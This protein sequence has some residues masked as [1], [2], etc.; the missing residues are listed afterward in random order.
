[1][2]GSAD[3]TQTYREMLELDPMSQVF[4]LLAEELCAEGKW[5][6]AAQVCTGGLR[7]HPAHTRA[8]VLLG[9]ALMELGEADQSETVL[10]SVEDEIR[11]NAI[12][13]KFLSEF[14][15]FSGDP[16]R[17]DET[18]RIYNAFQAPQGELQSTT[19]IP[20][21]L[22]PEI[23]PEPIPQPVA[24]PVQ[25]IAPEPAV[26][27]VPPPESLPAE[28]ALKPNPASR[29]ES[30]FT[31]VADNLES[32]SYEAKAAP[33]VFSQPDRNLLKQLLLFELRP[34]GR[35]S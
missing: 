4:A 35:S 5:E 21:P 2:A 34:N 14:A 30:L 17:A 24:A 28:A 13:F 7:Y 18:A 32:E 15:A 8:R 16:A 33:A 23:P 19:P 9:W 27:L 10:R 6:E 3:K 11:K 20:A 12:A 25:P 29:L 1:M 31:A 26:G 22:M